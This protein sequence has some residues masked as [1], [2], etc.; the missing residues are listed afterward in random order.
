[1]KVEDPGKTPET[2]GQP[3]SVEG[4][5]PPTPRETFK[6]VSH[7]AVCMAYDLVDKLR[8][9]EKDTLTLSDEEIAE[10]I[11]HVSALLDRLKTAYLDFSDVDI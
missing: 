1:M 9:L 5:V 2:K 8:W 3:E 11:P 7:I 6:Q 10:R 4:A